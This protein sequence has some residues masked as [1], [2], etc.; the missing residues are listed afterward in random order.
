LGYTYVQPI[1]TVLP[2]RQSTFDQDLKAVLYQDYAGGGTVPSMLGESYANFGPIGWIVVPA[3]SAFVLVRLYRFAHEQRTVA[4]WALYAWVLVHL[5][6][7]TISGIIVAN[8]FPYPAMV[9]LGGAA[10]LTRR[11]LRANQPAAA[12]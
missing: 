12:D 2:G 8:I 10:L 1:V 7:A 5:V 9:I 4:A 11:P 3:I 6:N